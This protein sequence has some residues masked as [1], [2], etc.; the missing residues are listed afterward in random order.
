MPPS[1]FVFDNVVLSAFYTADW[2]DALAFWRP[3]YDLLVPEA[4]WDDEFVPY[5]DID[6][7]PEWLDVI[8]VESDMGEEF[9]GALSEIDWRCIRLADRESGIVVTRDRILK[10]IA[11]D[12]DV[13]TL[14]D[15]RF[16]IDTFEACGISRNAYTDGVAVYLADAGDRLPHSVKQAVRDAEKPADG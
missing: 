16:V 14:W 5:S 3:E 11:E 12:Q 9:P 13:G 10:R 6:A 1:A 8:E 4:L 2:F 7:T 15:A